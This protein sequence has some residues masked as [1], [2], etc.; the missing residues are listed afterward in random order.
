MEKYISSPKKSKVEIYKG[1]SMLK[2]VVTIL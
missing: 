1:I 2:Q